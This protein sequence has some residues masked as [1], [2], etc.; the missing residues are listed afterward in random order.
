MLCFDH[1]PPPVWSSKVSERTARLFADR[2]STRWERDW[3][4]EF[5]MYLRRRAIEFK[6]QCLWIVFRSHQCPSL[7]LM[8]VITELVINK[9]RLHGKRDTGENHNGLHL[10]NKKKNKKI[11]YH[12]SS[13]SS[14][15]LFV[16]KF[17]T[18]KKLYNSYMFFSYV[19]QVENM[20]VL[21][22]CMLYLYDV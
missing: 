11:R 3:S 16:S 18:I 8:F 7:S 5:A 17:Q 9:R 12:Y 22:T 10:Y 1:S 15:F 6:I 20:Y 19:L 4:Y 14:V 21:F 2:S 13:K